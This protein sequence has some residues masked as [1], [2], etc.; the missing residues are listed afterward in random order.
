[1]IWEYRNGKVYE[2]FLE[3]DYGSWH[4]RQMVIA[5]STISKYLTHLLVLQLI[6]TSATEI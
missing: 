3:I 2:T 5:D 1:M 4:K 6:E